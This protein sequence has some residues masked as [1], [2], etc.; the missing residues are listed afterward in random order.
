MKAP[1]NLKPKLN[2]NYLQLKNKNKHQTQ[3]KKNSKHVPKMI[4][5]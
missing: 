5:N 3:S 1:F 4:V 2:Q